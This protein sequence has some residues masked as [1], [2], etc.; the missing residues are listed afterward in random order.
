MNP[1]GKHENCLEQEVMQLLCYFVPVQKDQGKTTGKPKTADII[2]T[3]FSKSV[4]YSLE[5]SSY[6]NYYHLN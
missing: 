6:F 1:D 5:Y 3:L 2:A 4:G